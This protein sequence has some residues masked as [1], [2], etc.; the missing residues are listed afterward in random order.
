MLGFNKNIEDDRTESV[1][2]EVNETVLLHFSTNPTKTGFKL[3]LQRIYNLNNLKS[4]Y[5]YK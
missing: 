1:K 4:S 3:L 5:A 2:E